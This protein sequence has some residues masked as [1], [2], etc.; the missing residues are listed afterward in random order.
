MGGKA[1]LLLV[2]AFSAL[3]GIMGTQILR[4]A[5]EATDSYVHYYKKTKAHDLAV[6]GANMAVNE[7]FINKSWTTGYNNLAM[8]YGIINV[9]VDLSVI[10]IEKY[11]L[12]VISMV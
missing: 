2:L 12:L 1:S 8:D 10:I 7:I 3:F 5:N 9:W 4:T 11:I 6:S